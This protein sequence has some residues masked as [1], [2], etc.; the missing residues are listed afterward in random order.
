[1]DEED[2]EFEL[3]YYEC[4]YLQQHP[5]NNKQHHKQDPQR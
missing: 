4:K 1:M 2:K 3:Y 5:D